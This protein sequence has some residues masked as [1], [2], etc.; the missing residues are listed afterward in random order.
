M[1]Q[2]RA[3]KALPKKACG[4]RDRDYEELSSI[5]SEAERTAS[6]DR[7]PLGLEEK[8]DVRRRNWTWSSFAY[9]L[10]VGFVSRGHVH[11]TQQRWKQVA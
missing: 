10:L 11:P 7:S 1:S 6:E 4:R 5:F 8:T 2:H 9:G 3:S